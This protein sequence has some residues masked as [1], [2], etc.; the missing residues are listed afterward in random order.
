MECQGRYIHYWR[1]R[2]STRTAG[3]Y[4]AAARDV[5]FF[6]VPDTKYGE[7]VCAWI[8]LKDNELANKE[9]IKAFCK[10]QIAHFKV[11]RYIRFVDEYPMT[12]TGKIQKFLMREAMVEELE[13][14]EGKRA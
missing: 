5:Q 4:R 3:C 6:G 8:Q 2:K 10:G 1:W 9:E 7:E 11:P 12:V 14:G 13:I